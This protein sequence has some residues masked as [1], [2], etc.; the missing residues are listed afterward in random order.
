MRSPFHF[1]I[2]QTDIAQLERAMLRTASPER[3]RI[4]GV[5][6]SEVP[7]SG[8]RLAPL[9]PDCVRSPQDCR[10]A[11]S[12]HGRDMSCGRFDRDAGD[13]RVIKRVLELPTFQAKAILVS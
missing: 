9:L 13:I 3:L 8:R 11:S 12:L 4:V 7:K 1:F 5:E 10:S 6:E 2:E